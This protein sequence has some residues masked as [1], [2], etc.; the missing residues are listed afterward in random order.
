MIAMFLVVSKSKECKVKTVNSNST[1]AFLVLTLA[2]VVT[3][4]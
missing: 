3:S 4:E 1:S 2:P